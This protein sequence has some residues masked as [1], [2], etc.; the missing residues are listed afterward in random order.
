MKLLNKLTKK[1]NFEIVQKFLEKNNQFELINAGNSMPG[2]LVNENGCIQ[3][4]PHINQMD[5]T[6]A[7]KFHR[8]R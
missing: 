7:A 1:E 3:T 2:E 5:G 6:F 4:Y 8:V